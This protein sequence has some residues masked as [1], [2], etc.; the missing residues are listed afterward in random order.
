[1]RLN[2]DLTWRYHPDRI[3]PGV[4]REFLLLRAI[5]E[6][7]PDIVSFRYRWLRCQWK[8]KRIGVPSTFIQVARLN[9]ATC[10]G[11]RARAIRVRSHRKSQVLISSWSQQI[12]RN[13]IDFVLESNQTLLVTGPFSSFKPRSQY[14][15]SMVLDWLLFLWDH[16]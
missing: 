2:I 9:R 13:T 4:T 6:E 1:M 12:D 15:N 16:Q 3:S 10:L 14:K 11:Y 8:R 7:R 5:G